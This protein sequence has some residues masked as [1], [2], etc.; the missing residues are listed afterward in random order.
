[1]EKIINIT[2]GGR[3]I[4]I[5]DAA[6]AKVQTYVESLREYFK[7]EEGRDE[8]VTDIEA[9]FAELMHEK[10]RKGAAHITETDVD[11]M[12]ATL[13][14]PEDFETDAS[15]A[16]GAT[17]HFT[18]TEKRRLYRDQNNKILGGVCS[19]I[20]NWLKID[21]TIV[22]I[23]FAI[24]TFGGYGTGF[25]IYI[26]LWIFLP[27]RNMDVYDGKRMFRDPDNKWLGG[28]AGGIGAYF[29]INTNTIRWVLSIPLILSAL[30]GMNAF[31][32]NNDFDIFPNLVFNGLSGTFIFL[33]IILWIILPEAHTPYQKMEMRGQPIDVNSIKQNVQSSMGDMSDRLKNW[34]KEVKDSAEKIGQKANEFTRSRGKE[35]GKEFTYV[36]RRSS[37]GIGYVIAMI[38]KA[39][40]V[41]IG[42]II[43]ISLLGILLTFLFSGFAFAPINN[44][45]WTSD[46]QQMLGWGTLI[47]FIG[48]PIIGM[49]VWLV[50][51]IFHIR[52]PG[53]YLN[54]TFGG[55]WAI[56]WVCLMFFLAS[57]S[58]DLKRYESV[59]TP[60]L[61]SQPSGNKIIFKVTQPKLVYEG[62][63]GWI[64]S[65]NHDWEGLNINSD[66]LK[67]SNIKLSFEK[68]D[69]TLYHFSIIKHA[70]GK[71]DTDAIARAE[72][73]NYNI[74]LNDSIADMAPGFA[75]DKDTKYRLQNIIILVKVPV[76]KKINIEESVFEKLSN[77]NIE[78]NNRLKWGGNAKFVFKDSRR[79]RTNTDYTMQSDGSLI[80]DDNETIQVDKS[81]SKS[82][83]NNDNYRWKG[84]DGSDT[85]TSIIAPPPPLPPA[86]LSDT[87]Q[88]YHYNENPS[89]NKT[90]EQIIKE[91]EQKQKEIEELKKKI[92]Q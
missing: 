42:A 28:V 8:I 55:L 74:V 86:S 2:L 60:I 32:W 1:M 7:N 65:N 63:F 26:G 88:I 66:T 77:M 22:R 56:G 25:L 81:S 39:I 61:I 37:R 69:D 16:T 67:L 57:V 48:I 73:I 34:S 52:T 46:T 29:N 35:F 19:G 45:L 13:G 54:W 30:R 59:E 14:R 38:F 82:K 62:N 85:V 44:F 31:G 76:G 58:G 92:Q 90:K 75:V 79:Y 9:R 18:F 43:A 89:D 83:T 84:F 23:L 17:P 12:I 15:G 41:F 51:K 71:S 36:A 72:K 87:S 33:Y 40:F 91:L 53:N 78:F 27:A 68:S 64:N 21:P 11:E 47:L 49:F 20:A 10:L 70:L 80:S 3:S 24:V 50:R 5:E 6:Y 4:A